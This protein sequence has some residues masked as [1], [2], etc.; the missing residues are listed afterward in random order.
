[1]DIVTFDVEHKGD[2]VSAVNVSLKNEYKENEKFFKIKDT[3]IKL[4]NIKNY[5]IGHTKLYY[6]YKY[7]VAPEIEGAGFWKTL[8]HS[9]R[10]NERYVLD[11]RFVLDKPQVK[12]AY[13][14]IT[15][16]QGDNFKF[17]DNLS[18]IPSLES[19]GET[20]AQQQISRLDSILN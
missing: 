9:K 19:V 2:K 14:Y 20:Y 6:E 7:D 15:T 3:R 11:N 1:M 5:G 18:N 10:I 4:N 17:F 13:F 8:F 12:V 16:Y